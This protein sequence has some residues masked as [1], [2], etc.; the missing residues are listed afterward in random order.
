MDTGRN[1]GVKRAPDGPGPAVPH[2]GPAAAQ[3]S[4]PAS[5]WF[6]ISAAR[7]CLSCRSMGSLPTFMTTVYQPVRT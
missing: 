5:T 6:R 3:V 7:K 2:G 1:A 4:T